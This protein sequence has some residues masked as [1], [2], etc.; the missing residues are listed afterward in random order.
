[1]ELDKPQHVPYQH[2]DV[3]NHKAT[4]QPP[5]VGMEPDTRRRVPQQRTPPDSEAGAPDL[6]H[7]GEAAATAAFIA[8]HADAEE[9]AAEAADDPGHRH[10]GQPLDWWHQRQFRDFTSHLEKFRTAEDAQRRARTSKRN[11]ATGVPGAPIYSWPRGPGLESQSHFPKV[12]SGSVDVLRLAVDLEELAGTDD[13]TSSPGPLQGMFDVRD[14]SGPEEWERRDGHPAPA[15]GTVGVS[16]ME[17]QILHGRIAETETERQE[18]TRDTVCPRTRERR[19]GVL[20]PG[21]AEAERV[22]FGAAP[23]MPWGPPPQC[24]QRNHIDPVN[25]DGEEPERHKAKVEF[26]DACIKE[27][28]DARASRCTGTVRPH[29]VCPLSVVEKATPPGQKQK[30]RMVRAT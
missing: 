5:P 25:A 17:G 8:A 19:A 11:T 14:G 12:T 15:A 24:V 26:L 22:V 23:S 7:G 28:S 6:H 16:S 13:G 4:A 9:R 2:Y 21:S 3:P 1:M 30:W 29:C 10:R 20:R 27:F 18:W